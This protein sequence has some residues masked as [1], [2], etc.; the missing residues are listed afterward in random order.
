MFYNFIFIKIKFRLEAM[1]FVSLGILYYYRSDSNWTSQMGCIL[2]RFKGFISR[3]KWKSCA[4]LF[5][6]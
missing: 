4:F 2:C 5:I 6:E 3:Y 1:D